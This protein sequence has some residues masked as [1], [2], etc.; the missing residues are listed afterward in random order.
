MGRLRKQ[1]CDF[2]ASFQQNAEDGLNFLI[3]PETRRTATGPE[4]FGWDQVAVAMDLFPQTTPL[5]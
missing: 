3:S 1:L 4:G 2:C 5:E